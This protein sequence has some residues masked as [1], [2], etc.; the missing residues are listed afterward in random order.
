MI[1]KLNQHLKQR[2]VIGTAKRFKQCWEENG[3]EYTIRQIF[4][5]IHNIHLPESIAAPTPVE[6]EEQPKVID[7][8]VPQRIVPRPTALRKYP[9]NA[10]DTILELRLSDCKGIFVQAPVIDW[11]VPL[12]QRPQHMAIAMANAGYLVFYIS[13]NIYDIVDGFVEVYPNLFITNRTDLPFTLKGAYVSVYS[14][15]SAYNSENLTAIKKNNRIV[16][17]YIDHIDPQISGNATEFLLN[18]FNYIN[19]NTVDIVAISGRALIEDF[20]TKVSSD[21]VVYVP[22]GVEF[23]HYQSLIHRDEPT[24]QLL[25][26]IVAKKKP[27]VGYFGALA[28]WLWYELVDHV[29]LNMPDFEFIFIGPDYYG[30]VDQLPKRDN[31]HYLGTIDYKTLPQYAK[32]FDV[33]I[34]PFAHGPIAKTTSPL[35]LFEYFALQKPVVVTSEMMECIAFEEVLSGDTPENFVLQL[36]KAYSLRN[37]EDLKKRLIKKAVENSWKMRAVALS[38]KIESK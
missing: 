18:Q 4:K 25:E 2:G 38:K 29:T 10:L 31:V 15:S 13:S 6:A 17:E 12:F 14:T 19:D 32:Y 7:S 26:P 35:K 20:K 28:P 27:I 5:P 11:E 16:Y 30:G 34:I 1:T 36:R 3:F 33:A 9:F 24:P 23:E 37:D 21:K 8:S 22:N